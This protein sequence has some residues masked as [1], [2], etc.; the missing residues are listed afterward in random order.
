[1]PIFDNKKQ[2][3]AL[4]AIFLIILLI[5]LYSA[6][7]TPNFTSPAYFEK[8]QIENILQTGFPLSW[9]PL[10]YSGRE[11]ITTPVYHY[12]LAGLSYVIGIE[13]ALKIMP[14]LFISLLSI[15]IFMIVKRLTSN[16]VASLMS[17]ALIGFIPVL[18]V[19]TLLTSSPYSLAFLLMFLALYLFVNL[20]SGQ[21]LFYFVMVVLV[22]PFVHP[23]T[24]IF[25]LGLLFYFILVRL[26]GLPINITE[27]EAA[28]FAL[29]SMTLSLFMQFR[30]ALISN[31]AAIIWQNIPPQIL[32]QYFAGVGILSYISM[33]GLIPLVFGVYTIYVY[34][35]KV[36]KPI[37]QVFIGMT[38]VL[39]LLIWLKFIE[40]NV[41][42]ALI[43][44]NL[45]ILTGEGLNLFFNYIQ[46]TKF[47]SSQ[48]IF[49]LVIVSIFLFTSVND[50]IAA[51]D[52]EI[53]QTPNPELL[54]I[55]NWTGHQTPAF[56]VIFGD[57][58]FG[59]FITGIAHRKNI[60]D[61]NYILI[62]KPALILDNINAIKD[63]KSVVEAVK[64]L[65]QY[66]V[67]YLLL[68]VKSGYSFLEDRNCF[69]KSYSNEKYVIYKSLCTV[70]EI[71]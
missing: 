28:L 30:E 13:L 62:D 29:F 10:S 59:N 39:F 48:Y 43:A 25:L 12:L 51:Q 60:I 44:I 54:D 58:E 33:V 35:A 46:Q 63:T 68:P 70:E 11:Y 50:T 52:S 2:Q 38:L 53:K 21:N 47:V 61:D 3:A 20:E 64:L 5:K 27:L 15:L 36:N 56:S 8:R 26:D 69:K 31:G 41:G 7:Q 66:N 45:I 18:S 42:L 19:L 40:P 9:D 6:F 37:I 4:A 24:V 55:L 49:L 34:T 17:A 22:L 57:L 1:M 14:N 23:I 32:D 67:D 71:A 65:S 16:P